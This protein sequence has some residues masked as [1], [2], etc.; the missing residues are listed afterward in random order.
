MVGFR[1]SSGR[2]ADR[3]FAMLASLVEMIDPELFTRQPT[4][5]LWAM[6]LAGFACLVFGADRAVGAAAR[7]AAALGMSKVLIGATI[8]SIGT[9]LPEVTVSVIAAFQDLPDLAMG[10]AI[11][12]VIFNTGIIF[13]HCAILRP[14]PK[15]RFLLNRHGWIQLGAALLLMVFMLWAWIEAG[16]I[17]RARLGRWVGVVF[18]AILA[19][20][21]WLSVGWSRR[22]P[23][24]IPDEASETTVPMDTGPGV[25]AG[26]AILLM[27]LG[28][29]MVGSELMVG[30]VKV[31]CDRM[32][33][34][35]EVIAVTV[36]ALGTSLPELATGI[37]SLIKGH[38]ELLVGNVI[39]ANILNILLV[40]GAAALPQ[41]L[42]VK[43]S[44]Y[45]L[46]VP[47]MLILLGLV[48]L[49]G[50]TRGPTFKRRHGVPMLAVYL[51]FYAILAASLLWFG[52]EL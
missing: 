52:R 45:W 11:G 16:D 39:G 9:T 4:P 44:F 37:T 29:V 38:P 5:L 43:P 40:V 7:L 19:G 20:Y 26:V 42:V 14:L 50:S 22:H 46:Y 30:S 31:I 10:N 12:S 2:A 1:L 6:I 47:A 51:V 24:L 41:G 8:V 15:D 27:G 13:G 35:P 28:L 32:K 3:V 34:P 33:I 48:R 36:V 25:L 18:L 21:L 23:E 17:D 49:L